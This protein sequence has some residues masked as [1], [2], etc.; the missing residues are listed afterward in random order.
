MAAGVGRRPVEHG[1]RNA[2]GGRLLGRH[3]RGPATSHRD[4]DETRPATSG[5]IPSS[6]NEGSRHRPRGSAARTP[7]WRGA[8]LDPS[9]GTALEVVAETLDRG[10]HGRAG[11]VGT[12]QRAAERG[13]LGVGLERRPDLLRVDAEG[14]A[15]GDGGQARRRPAGERRARHPYAVARRH[16]GAQGGRQ[17]QHEVGQVAANLLTGTTYAGR[18]GAR[19][20]PP[21]RG[22][23]DR[24][25]DADRRC[26]R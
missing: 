11:A 26:R 20:R 5:T 22:G 3:E 15:F 8:F 19:D 14:E 2:A 9:P 12:G 4:I 23:C 1:D 25:G 24:A 16:P 7:T 13:Q 18:L 10:H 6:R 17:Q 21:G